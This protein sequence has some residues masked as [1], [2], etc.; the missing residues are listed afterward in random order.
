MF[1]IIALIIP[2]IIE[3]REVQNIQKAYNICTAYGYQVLEAKF[4][5]ESHWLCLKTQA[6]GKC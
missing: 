1:L 6:I 2:Y 3:C 4:N 5:Q